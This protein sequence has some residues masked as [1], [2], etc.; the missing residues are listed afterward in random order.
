VGAVQPERSNRAIVDL[1][2]LRSNFALATEL[3]EGREVIAV[4]MA[5]GYGHGAVAVARALVDA[6]C[7][8]LAVLNTDEGALLRESGLSGSVL[9][10]GGVYGAREAGRAADYG[11]TPVLHDRAALERV[12]AAA[13]RAQRVLP[14]QVEIDTGMRR[15]GVSD[16]DALDFLADVAAEP[17]LSLEGVYTHLASADDPS[18]ESSLEQ[19]ARFRSVLDALRGRGIDP[20][21]VHA[22][23]SAGLLAGKRLADALP[24][25]A[26]VR[27]GLMLYGAR[28]ADHFAAAGRLRPVMSVR[29]RVLALRSVRAGDPV[30]YGGSWRAERDTRIA[31]LALGYE[32]GVLR[33]LASRGAVWLAGGRRPIVGRVSMDYIGV[34]V[35]DAP[36]ALGDEAVFFG[37]ASHPEPLASASDDAGIPVEEQARAAGTLAYELLVGVGGRVARQVVNDR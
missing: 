15:M 2:A 16:S 14:V 12:A 3:A 34:D 6:G 28:P 5:D 26:A 4:V 35:G 18:L 24:E 31:T 13:R 37:S 30:G 7:R 8:R 19:L 32:D 33:S 11:L 1:A 25:A 20:G 21:L 9:V 10:M 17:A 36:V 23:N 29:A 22:V 27:P